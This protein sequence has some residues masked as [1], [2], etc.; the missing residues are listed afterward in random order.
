MVG[1]LLGFL[2]LL[3]LVQIGN[4]A[5]L[6]RPAAAPTGPR[7]FVSV[8]IP[9]R[10]EAANL[11]RLIPSLLDQAYDAFEVIV[12]DDA[13]EDAT[14]D[15]LQSFEDGRLRPVRGEGPPDGWVGK[16]H[17]L[18][19]AAKIARGDVYFFVDADAELL[20]KYALG[21]L[22]DRHRS[23]G[24][25]GVLT[26]FTDLRGNGL[27]LV[28][29][30]PHTILTLLP[31]FL[32]D[33]VPSPLIGSLNGQ[34]WIIEAGT[35]R[36]YAPHEHV[37][38]EVLE[39]VAIGRYLKGEG[40]SS[41]MVDVRRELAIYMYGSFADAWRGFRK[42]AYLLIGGQVWTFLPWWA[43]YTFTF[44]TAPFL[45]PDVL[46]AVYCLKILSDR[47]AGMPIWVTLLGPLAH[48]A[49]AVLQ[50]DSAVSHWTGR[51]VWKGRRVG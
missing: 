20:D 6:R 32:V 19:Q 46:A 50:L 14:W 16:V 49:G 21:R 37:R 4:I 9:A 11:R 7:P 38:N 47:A 27:L 23:L 13:S 29:L 31:W 35:Y 12:Y 17:A 45:W 1:I 30:L 36:R 3:L 44:A 18:F 15:V 22:I 43:I 28:S 39:D 8:L 33:R 41:V 42:N 26:G 25:H 10:N 34:C 48:V 51:A 24:E 40:V 5:Y 2:A